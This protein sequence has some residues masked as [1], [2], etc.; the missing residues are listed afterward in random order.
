[1]LKIKGLTKL[2]GDKRAVDKLTLNIAD[3]KQT[4]AKYRARTHDIYMGEWSADYLDPH[5]NAQGF[6]W[7]PDN[8]DASPYKMLSWRNAWDIPDFTK[9]TDE[10]LA[11]QD[12]AKRAALY[13]AMQKDFQPV[14]PYVVMFNKVSQVAMQSNVKDFTVG[15]IYDLV[16]YRSVKKN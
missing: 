9:R 4:L 13:Q 3:N 6:A 1:M 15:P 11:E 16:Q 8:S 2:Y 14:S 12:T 5:S 7:N 10:A